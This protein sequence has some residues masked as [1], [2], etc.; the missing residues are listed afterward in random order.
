MSKPLLVVLKNTESP[1]LV[2]TIEDKL[3]VFQRL[4]GGYIENIQLQRSGR[5]VIGLV[6]NEM[7]AV[8]HDAYPGSSRGE[9][10]PYHFSI[11]G[12][13]GETHI[14]GNVVI[15][16]YTSAGDNESLT[17]EEAEHWRKTL[18]NWAG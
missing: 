13:A 7:G 11:P 6:V 18:N 4:V 17:A 2:A 10:L 14:H 3:S 1:A 12:R 15:A 9:P 16:K 5:S 8:P